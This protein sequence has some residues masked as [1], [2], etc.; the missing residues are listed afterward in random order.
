[1]G[2]G[3]K[4]TLGLWGGTLDKDEFMDFE[5]ER[6]DADGSELQCGEPRCYKPRWYG[7]GKSV[8]K[9]GRHIDFACNPLIQK[10]YP[11]RSVYLNP[12]VFAGVV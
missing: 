10:D 8:V 4:R 2:E 3:A 12:I 5:Y 6:Q 7:P 11:S 1:V 9:P